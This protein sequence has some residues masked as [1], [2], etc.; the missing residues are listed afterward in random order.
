VPTDWDAKAYDRVSDPQARWALDVVARIE[1]RPGSILDAGCGSGRVT[2]LLLDRFPDSDVIAVDSSASMID[3]ARER[4]ERHGKRV[5]LTEQS[6]LRP[7]PF[8]VDVIFSNA[9]FHWIGDHDLLFANLA[10][11]LKPG[12]QLV[13]QWGGR[14]NVARLFAAVDTLGVCG[15]HPRRFATAEET[16]DRLRNAG[17]V[18]VRTWL[19]SDAADF[20]TREAFED[21]LRT[22]C[23]RCHL[24]LLA[25]PERDAFVRSVADLVPDRRVD[26]VRLNATARRRSL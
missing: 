21:Y 23:L 9:V 4:L 1:G 26:Y 20:A 14:G 17:F 19:H 15:P 8:S 22:V 5:V 2:E 13:A 11:C 6:L 18:D 16:A 7:I 24:D 12:G 25:E 3:Q 10:A